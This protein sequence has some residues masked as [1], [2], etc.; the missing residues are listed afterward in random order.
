[1]MRMRVTLIQSFRFVFNHCFRKLLQPRCCNF[2]FQILISLT[3]FR[4]KMYTEDDNNSPSYDDFVD[5]NRVSSFLEIL[6][7]VDN[8]AD[9]YPYT[10]MKRIYFPCDDSKTLDCETIR[11]PHDPLVRILCKTCAS[12]HIFVFVSGNSSR[13]FAVASTSIGCSF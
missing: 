1:M 5:K 2:L 13:N 10:V 9:F 12:C 7:N 8:G 11:G 4:D 3:H 6:K